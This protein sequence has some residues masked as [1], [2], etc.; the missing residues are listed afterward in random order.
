[1]ANHNGSEADMEEVTFFPL[2]S[3]KGTEYTERILWAWVLRKRK[4][5]RI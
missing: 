1:M 4:E 2:Y 5:P 3:S